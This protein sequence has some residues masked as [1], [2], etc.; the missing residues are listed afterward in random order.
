VPVFFTFIL[1]LLLSPPLLNSFSILLI[2][3]SLS[4]CCLHIPY[5]VT[6]QWNIAQKMQLQN[7]SLLCGALLRWFSAGN[8]SLWAHTHVHLFNLDHSRFVYL[9]KECNRKGHLTRP[10]PCKCFLISAV[11]KRQHL[12]L[13]W[14][15]FACANTHKKCP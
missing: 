12:T 8:C 14:P 7:K 13:T 5:I 1:F 3:L 4:A 10:I 6:V 2:C 9:A 11:S 15:M